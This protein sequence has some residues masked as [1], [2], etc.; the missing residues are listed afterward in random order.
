[1]EGHAPIL[2]KYYLIH[3]VEEALDVAR[4]HDHGRFRGSL[5]STEQLKDATRR[6]RVEAGSRFVAQQITGVMDSGSRQTHP[7]LLPSRETPDRTPLEATKSHQL[8]SIAHPARNFGLIQKTPSLEG[9]SDISTDRHVLE[10]RD[11]LKGH[12]ELRLK[13][14]ALEITRPHHLSPV[15]PNAPGICLDE[16]SE[17]SQQQALAGARR[18]DHT[19]HRPTV[20]GELDTA[21]RWGLEG[22]VQSLHDDHCFGWYATFLAHQKQRTLRGPRRSPTDSQGRPPHEWWC[23]SAGFEGAPPALRAPLP[24]FAAKVVRVTSSFG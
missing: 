8:E 17:Y 23:R 13:I 3:D 22:L 6:H 9:K 10:E 20:D 16:P 24:Q 1:M 15:N 12:P 19:H 4:D 7:T 21:K 14:E 18:A 5:L 11:V 2:Q